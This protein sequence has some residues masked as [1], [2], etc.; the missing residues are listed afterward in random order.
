MWYWSGHLDW[1]ERQ[2]NMFSQTNISIRFN[3][4][5]CLDQQPSAPASF[6]HFL[7]LE[8]KYITLASEIYEQIDLIVVVDNVFRDLAHYHL[9]PLPMLDWLSNRPLTTLNS[10][11]W[12]RSLGLEPRWFLSEWNAIKLNE[13]YCI[14]SP[15]VD[16]ALNSQISNIQIIPSDENIFTT[17]VQSSLFREVNP[18]I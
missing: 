9:S 4:S 3:F 10:G 18:E 1:Q 13:N 14:L 15:P 12:E 17:S 8:I 6:H 5:I 7:I 11:C 16:K 2:D